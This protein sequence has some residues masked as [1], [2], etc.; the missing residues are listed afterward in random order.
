MRLPVT[1]VAG[2][3]LAL[4]LSSCAGGYRPIFPAQVRTYQNHGTDGNAVEFGYQYSALQLKGGNR[5]YIKKERKRGYQTI[6]VR[7]K[8]N[9][10]AELNF[11]RDLELYFGDRPAIPVPSLQAA[12]D[13]KQGVVIYLLYGLLN[14]SVGGTYNP[15][16]GQT[17]GATFIPTGPF[18][19]AGNMIGAGTANTNLRKE[20]VTND[21][22]NKVIRPGETVYGII[23]LREMN[24]APLRLVLRNPAA[25]VPAP[26]AQPAAPAPVPTPATAPAPTNGGQ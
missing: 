15:T 1:L 16:T 12:N 19:A 14:F 18:I 5:K 24:I 4:A 9:T 25:A 10:A 13:L 11:S 7:V 3:A 22:T 26:A 2:G 17:T 20:F 21:L 6:A 8:N 23:S